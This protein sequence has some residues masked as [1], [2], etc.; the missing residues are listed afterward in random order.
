MSKRL[1]KLLALAMCLALLC[2]ATA[3]EELSLEGLSL[4]ELSLQNETLPVDQTAQAP[5][6]GLEIDLSADIPVVEAPTDG[7]VIDLSADIPMGDA[8][9]ESEVKQN[10]SSDFVIDNGILISYQGPGGDVVVPNIVTAINDG[11]FWCGNGLDPACVGRLDITSVTLPNSVVRI[12]N[13]AFKGCPLNRITLPD[14]IF[15]IGSEAFR[16]SGLTSVV[17][18][19]LVDKI[20]Y[21]TFADCKSL[22]YAIL[23][24]GLVTVGDYAFANSSLVEIT[25][26]GNVTSVGEYAFSDCTLLKTAE[27]C[28]GVQRIDGH[29]FQ[30]CVLLT[31][32][33]LPNT[34]KVMGDWTFYNDYCLPS[35]DIP[36]SLSIIPTG[37]FYGCSQLVRA[38]IPAGVSV[39]GSQA[40]RECTRLSG[41]NADGK[42]KFAK[43]LAGILDSAFR[44]CRAITNVKIDGSMLS[45]GSGAFSGCT[46]LKQITVYAHGDGFTVASFENI[47]PSAHFDLYCDTPLGQWAKEQM[48]QGSGYTFSV[49]HNV[50]DD[51]EVPPTTESTGLTAGKHC[52]WCGEIRVAQKDI[53]RLPSKVVLDRSGTVSLVRGKTLQLKATLDP[54][55]SA[56]T[57]KWT[58][59]N[60]A[61]ATVT[62]S[63]KVKAIK[64]GTAT[65][66]VRTQN[67]KTAK[68]KIKVTGPAPKKVKITN[69]SKATMIVGKQL[70]L[71]TTLTPSD[72]DTKLTW[73]SSN[74]KVA[75]VNGK[76]LV[77][78]KKAGKAK[79]TV[80]TSNGKK[81]TIT[82]TVKKK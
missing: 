47:D 57:L 12:G 26:P 69:G 8:P 3:A 9:A 80:R 27:I 59:S 5:V 76:G 34:L 25:I 31:S 4:D 28:E 51:P 78:A 66:T 17:I 82:I 38:N 16:G 56:S 33:K 41:V 54:S 37:A 32:V 71:K 44:D 14:S 2:A 45:L 23:S 73:S 39:I 72:A 13:N 81:A 10:D 65:I 22:K 20:E 74:K 29:A 64:K 15:T 21:C 6:D 77:T 63:G 11:A 67:K 58:S 19:P 48:E 53:P 75:A 43:T 70:Q 55:D 35:I 1:K 68:V 18:P 60:S 62:Q 61:V 79:I 46:R 30:N 52:S 49:T 50:V 42:L 24:N 40:F 7:L 36:M